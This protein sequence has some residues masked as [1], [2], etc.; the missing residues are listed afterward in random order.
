[1]VQADDILCRLLASGPPLQTTAWTLG[2]SAM[3]VVLSMLENGRRTVVECGSGRSTVLLARCLRECDEGSVHSLEHD[4]AG[5]Q[6]P[7]PASRGKI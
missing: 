1:M 2:D 3:A 7:E 6:P 5:P 4:P